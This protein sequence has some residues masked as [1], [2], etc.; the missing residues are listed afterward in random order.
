MTSKTKD[1]DKAI[2]F[3]PMFIVALLPALNI[4]LFGPSSIYLAN[5]EE[6][7]TSYQTLIAIYLPLGLLLAAGLASLGLLF[8][9]LAR[10]VYVSLLFACGVLLWLQGAFL[11]PDYGQL[12]GR[13]LDWTAIQFPVWA[14]SLIWVVVLGAS[15][16]LAARAARIAAFGS[17]VFVVLQ[18][19]MLTASVMEQNE[20][21]WVKERPSA[22]GP[23]KGIHEFSRTRNIIHIVMDNFQTDVFADLVAEQ[24]L[25]DEFDG[26][27]LFR[28]NIAV[29]PNTAL[30]MPAIF[31]GRTYDGSVSPEEYYRQAMEEGFH[32]TLLDQ[33]YT[34]NLMPLMSMRQGQYSN[35]YTLPRIYRGSALDQ[36]KKDAA[37]LLDLSFFRQSPHQARVWIYNGNNWRLS[38]WLNDPETVLSYQQRRF[39]A[40]YIDRLETAVDGPAYHFVHLWPPHPPFTTTRS[41][42]YAGRVLENTLVNY[43]NE[44]RP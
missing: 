32:N 16:V 25:E 1:Q 30:A 28:E 2:A 40:D 5:A 7:G 21:F 38:M 10:A 6:F 26:F 12:D 34:V 19:T 43:V 24:G 36:V 41:G 20:Q 8:R 29:A 11:M 23:P 27:T 4:T 37:H 39:F 42:R 14:D 18:A 17:L 22:S 9:R 3:L 15:I 44:A 13:G 33:G 35:Y 31:S